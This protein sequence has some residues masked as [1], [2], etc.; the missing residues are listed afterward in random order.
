MDGNDERHTFRVGLTGGIA[1]GKSTV[2]DMFA[3]LGA[4]VI[5]TDVIARQ[6]VRPGQPALEEIQARF[7]EKIIGSG[8]QLDRRELR[9]LVFADAEARGDLESILHPKIA[10]ETLRQADVAE[11]DYQIIVVPL[12]VG[13]ALLQL[14]D[15]VLV[16][17]CSEQ[18]Q[19]A[20]LTRRDDETIGQA[21][22]IIAA[23]TS[24][25]ERLKIAD[26]VIP[27]EGQIDTMRKYVTDLHRRYCDLASRSSPPEQPPGTP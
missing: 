22:R 13:S 10:L 7:G 16:I 6:L 18:V 25:E 14:L 9:R 4:T 19:I 15:R 20:R 5:D 23:Q 24:R 8:G 12:L 2:A 27:N 3:E 21:E 17:D 11:G 1:S 26:D